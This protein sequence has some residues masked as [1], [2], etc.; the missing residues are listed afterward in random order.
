MRD[1]ILDGLDVEIEDARFCWRADVDE[2]SCKV[3]GWNVLE[4]AMR[5]LLYEAGN[6]DIERM[7]IEKGWKGEPGT[8][9]PSWSYP[10]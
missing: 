8:S 6:E 7:A 4:D 5:R 9:E 10:D 2:R 1:N 3:E